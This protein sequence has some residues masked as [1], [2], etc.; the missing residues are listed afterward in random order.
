M[1]TVSWDTDRTVHMTYEY[2]KVNS[3]STWSEVKAAI[4]EVLNTDWN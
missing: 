4:L 2:K 3:V 1:N